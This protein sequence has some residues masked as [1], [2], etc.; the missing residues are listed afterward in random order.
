[1]KCRGQPLFGAPPWK[2]HFQ[3]EEQEEKQLIIDQDQYLPLHM[4][5]YVTYYSRDTSYSE[6]KHVRESMCVIS[7]SFQTKGVNSTY[8]F[9]FHHQPF[10]TDDLFH[11]LQ[12]EDFLD[13]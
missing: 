9:E 5:P 12:N 3:K 1:M 2:M 6:C 4:N 13:Q 8:K 10:L 11:I 7:S